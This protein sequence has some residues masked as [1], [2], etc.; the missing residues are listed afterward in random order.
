MSGCVELNSSQ[1]GGR[2]EWDPSNGR[3]KEFK[4]QQTRA[5]LKYRREKGL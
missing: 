1:G 4:R 3:G 2:D 5:I